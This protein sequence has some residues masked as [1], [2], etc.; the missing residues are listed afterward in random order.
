M[1]SSNQKTLSTYE[2]YFDRYIEG[3]PT[4]TAGSQKEWIDYLLSLESKDAQIL[5]VG[6]AFGRDAQ[7]ITEKG[8]IN[9]HAS[10][11]FDAA[12]DVLKGKG[13]VATKLNVL[14]DQIPK[15]YDMIIASAVLLHFTESEARD[16][17]QKVH[18]S[19]AV[20]GILAF[21]VKIGT[22][23]EWS[24]DKMQAPRFFHYWDEQTLIPFV[25]KIGFNILDVRTTENDKWLCVTAQ[26][27]G[28]E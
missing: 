8:Y 28:D 11:A 12:V 21:T 18:Q 23:E 5:E 3:T 9:L 19:I 2:Q 20:K 6:S 16:V 4:V 15:G 26:R 22:G 24:T 1:A 27:K 17:L 7:Y 13:F 10:D 14:T 25:E